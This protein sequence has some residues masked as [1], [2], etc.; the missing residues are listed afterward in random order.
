M[1]D[2]IIFI[3]RGQRR[4]SQRDVMLRRNSPNGGTSWTATVPGRVHQDEASG[5]SLQSI[6]DLLIKY[7]AR[8]AGVMV[9]REL[10]WLDLSRICSKTYQWN[11]CL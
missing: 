6:V 2:V 8:L 9:K 11:L 10:D 5:R 4:E 3:P 1:D 7:Q